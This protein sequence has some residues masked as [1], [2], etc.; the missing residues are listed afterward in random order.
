MINRTILKFSMMILLLSSTACLEST[1]EKQDAGQRPTPIDPS[2]TVWP[3]LPE[4]NL[5]HN[6]LRPD[7]TLV[8]NLLLYQNRENV[9][10]ELRNIET[11][12]ISLAQL[13]FI[14][15]RNKKLSGDGTP[16]T[17]TILTGGMTAEFTANGYEHSRYFLQS[18]FGSRPNQNPGLFLFTS[19]G[20]DDSF[21]LFCNHFWSNVPNCENFQHYAGFIKHVEVD[22]LV[23]TLYFRF[24]TKRISGTNTFTVD[25]SQIE[26]LQN[27]LSTYAQWIGRGNFSVMLSA[28]NDVLGAN[29]DPIAKAEIESLIQEYDEI[30]LFSY[31]ANT[32]QKQCVVRPNKPAFHKLANPSLSYVRSGNPNGFTGY[33]DVSIGNDT[34]NLKVWK[35]DATRQ[36]PL[37]ELREDI[38]I[39]LK[40]RT[41]N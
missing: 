14:G 41:C 4:I 16:P 39:D 7:F 38:T 15:R 27:T 17:P 35:L 28:H 12:D 8:S 37:H 1:R 10:P 29:F 11:N 18:H 25:Q 2:K 34:I 31:S 23:H 22:L 21:Q 3:D 24:Q 26:N 20:G 6:R 5:D 36:T 19:L 9:D 30:K 13:A 40:N 33:T 32:H